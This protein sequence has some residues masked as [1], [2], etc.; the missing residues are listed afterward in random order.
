MRRGSPKGCGGAASTAF[1]IESSVVRDADGYRALGEEPWLRFASI[2]LFQRSRFI[3]IG[4]ATN[5]F[6]AP[7]RPLLRFWTDEGFRE[8]ILPGPCDNEGAFWIGRVPRACRAVWIS[9]TNRIGPFDFRVT[10]LR[11]ASRL[12][13]AARILRAPLRFFYAVSASVVGLED[14]A[15]LNWRWTLA[16]P[17]A[18]PERRVRQKTDPCA[19]T[20][21]LRPRSR[22]RAGPLIGVVLGLCAAIGTF[23]S[24]FLA[25]R[26][27]KRHPN[28][29]SWLPAL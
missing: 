8:H 21:S 18:G 6:D 14:E 17:P 22:W 1:E 23:T 19:A 26:I 25:D 27:S 10:E 15:E 13:L 11:P 20:G 28:A 16:R 5:L 24:G 29:L 3:S 9:P 7:V 2:E 4:Y 12:E